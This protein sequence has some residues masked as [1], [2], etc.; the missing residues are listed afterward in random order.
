[1]STSATTSLDK[2]WDGA[3]EPFK[4]SYGK[5][6]IW[7]F[8]LSDALTFSAF[9][10]G[11]GFFRFKFADT[12]PLA[13]EVFT[14]FP[15]LTGDHPLLYVA[16]MTFILIVSSVTM[17]LAVV[18]GHENKHKTVVFHLFLT[19]IGGIVFLLSQAWEWGHFIH[20]EY[21]ALRT[22]G[23]TTYHV[24]EVDENNFAHKVSIRQLVTQDKHSTITI[25]SQDISNAMASAPDNIFLRAEDRITM[26]TEDTEINSIIN[27]SELIEGASLRENE[28]G[29][30]LFAN[31]FFF[32]TGFHGFHVFSGVVINIIIFANVLLGTYKRR[33]SYEMVEKSGLYW[34]FVDLVWVFVFTFFYLV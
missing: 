22:K 14:H 29:K 4:A 26:V 2:I 30:T 33:K 7:F 34:H 18:A 11:Y 25:T 28:Y 10:V 20:G 9:L 17:V 32:I 21:G 6:M 15:F 3:N 5:M 16:L 12:W 13:E 19:I 27:S 31:L 1:M 24:V 8:L 23:N